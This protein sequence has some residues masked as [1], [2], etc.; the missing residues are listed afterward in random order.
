MLVW[1][2]ILLQLLFGL[3]SGFCQRMT[4]L[5]SPPDWNRLNAFQETITHDEFA[6]LLNS[7]Y[8]P[9]DAAGRWI[10]IQP[11]Q[12]LI[13]ENATET[14]VLRFAPAPT[15]RRPIFRYWRPVSE[16]R[17]PADQPLEGITVALDP[18]HLG[19]EWAKMEERWFQIGSSAPI[20][21]G[22]MTLRVAQLLAPRLRALGAKVELVRSKLG[23]VSDLRPDQLQGAAEGALRSQGVTN[24]APTFKGPTD[25]D[26]ER[27]LP[28]EEDLLFY[29]TGEIQARAR[30]VNETIRPDLTLCLHFNAEPWGDPANST[31]VD[32]NHLHLLI[33]GNYSTTELGYDDVRYAMLLK[34]LNRTYEEELTLSE[35]LAAGLARVTQLPAYHYNTPNAKAMDSTGYVWARNL[36]ANRLYE[37][38]VVYI[39]CYVMNS[40]EFFAR[41]QAGEYEGLQEFGGVLRPNIYQEYVEG[42]VNGLVDYFRANR[43][44][45]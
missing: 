45:K 12:A 35:A 19:G 26:K 38:P 5:S 14:F 41:F 7:V 27:S 3:T 43:A 37:C 32:S 2:F 16:M 22:N 21:E 13:R 20:M 6:T 17:A 40:H 30:I 23:P 24:I 28:W 34:L 1:I 15:A 31:L 9:S 4:P 8:A 39:E 11:E 44:S 29:R 18:G 33:N 25:P 36:L 10:K 42:V